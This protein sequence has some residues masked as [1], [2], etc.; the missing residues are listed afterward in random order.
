MLASIGPDVGCATDSLVSFRT[1]LSNI[2]EA[3]SKTHD[4]VMTQKTAVD[5]VLQSFSVAPRSRCQ[6]PEPMTPLEASQN[7][8]AESYTVDAQVPRSCLVVISSFEQLTR[9]DSRTNVYRLFHL[10]SFRRWQWLTLS[11]QIPC[12]SRYWAAIKTTQQTKVKSGKPR[13]LRRLPSC[14]TLCSKGFTSFYVREESSMTTQKWICFCRS[15]TLS[16]GDLRDFVPTH[17]QRL[18]SRCPIRARRYLICMI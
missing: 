8:F 14:L 18:I 6:T 2:E 1:Q 15:K 17:F 4:A 9:V 7:F 13:L 5:S 16:N 10:D 11:I 3:V 12:T